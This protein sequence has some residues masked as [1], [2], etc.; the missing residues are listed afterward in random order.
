MKCHNGYGLLI[1]SKNVENVGKIF[2][3]SYVELDYTTD[4]K[5]SYNLPPHDVV[6]GQGDKVQQNPE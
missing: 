5:P 6:S 2:K 4:D 1:N 3:L